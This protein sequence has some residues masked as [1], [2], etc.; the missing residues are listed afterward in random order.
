MAAAG[1]SFL[2]VATNPAI[3]R[4][5]RLEGLPRGV[6]RAAEILETP[7][8]K[9]IHAACVA[10]E[11][12]TEL[13]GSTT[14]GG[15]SGDLLLSLLEA[16]PISV[17]A[18]GVGARHAGHLHAGRRRRAATWPRSTSPA[19]TSP[20]TTATTSSPRSPTCQAPPA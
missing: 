2:A 11:L 12:G 10:A 6:V 16:E 8:G 15:R 4:V 20:T 17:H 1:P 18:I 9:A 5:A 7:G 3:D 13:G 14:A 19:A